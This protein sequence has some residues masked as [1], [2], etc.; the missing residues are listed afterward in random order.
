MFELAKENQV[1]KVSVANY[2]SVLFQQI[3]SCLYAKKLASQ[4]SLNVLFN[5]QKEDLHSIFHK[6]VVENWLK[7][8]PQRGLF[9]G[10]WRY[11]AALRKQQIWSNFPTTDEEYD[12]VLENEIIALLPLSATGCSDEKDLI[13]LAI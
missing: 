13:L 6:M 11:V 2:Y 5:E 10:G 9:Y 3:L 7:E 12:V 4:N 8:M 1:E